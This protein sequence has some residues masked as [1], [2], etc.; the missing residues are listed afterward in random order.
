M[1][2]RVGF[3]PTDHLHDQRF[4]RPPRSTAPAPLQIDF[5]RIAAAIRIDTPAKERFPCLALCENRRFPKEKMAERQGFEP[6][7]RFHDHT[8]S[9]R[10]PSTTRTPLLNGHLPAA[11]HRSTTLRANA[12]RQQADSRIFSFYSL[13]ASA[14][15]LLSGA[16]TRGKNLSAVSRTPPP[17][18]TA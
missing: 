12:K 1:A 14:P 8:L 9:R 3:E 13:P 17:K 10:A 5:L 18:P 4:S 2:E 11:D 15:P 16:A 6:W 7:S